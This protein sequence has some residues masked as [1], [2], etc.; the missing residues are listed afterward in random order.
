M[1][2][3]H[4]IAFS[5]VVILELIF[6]KPDISAKSFPALAV[7]SRIKGDVIA[8]TPKKLSKGFNSK[9]LWNNF[10]VK[11]ANNSST[12][13][14]FK[15]GSEIRLF[16]NSNLKIGAK[17][18]ASKRWIRYRIILIDGSFWG[19][20]TRG[21]NPV[22]IYQKGLEIHALNTSMRFSRTGKKFKIS[23]ISG[24]LK[25]FNNVSSLK[26][27]SGQRL[28]QIQKNDF[29]PQKISPIPNQLKIWIEPTNAR[30]LKDQSLFIDL[31]LQVVRSGTDI[32]I[33]RS[34]PIFLRSDY[35]NLILPNSILLN[36]DG[37]AK[38]KIEIKPPDIEDRTFSGSIIFEALMDQNGY[39]DVQNDS[40]KSNFS[41][42]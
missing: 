39:D 36:S 10:H 23:C 40:F 12:T 6:F 31:F 41:T 32:K 5:L 4:Y 16:G 26:L 1:I 14:F 17:K 18:P 9:M 13:I 2:F 21:N 15:D 34:G 42:P 30:F 38:T 29:L 24:Y 28:Y 19:Y 20:F 33:R 37:E 27:N 3:F 22:E 7:L 35:Y 25:V 8:G 11:T